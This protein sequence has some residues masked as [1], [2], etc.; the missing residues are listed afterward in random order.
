MDYEGDWGKGASGLELFVRDLALCLSVH[1]DRGPALVWPDGVDAVLS[2][3]G[4][5]RRGRADPGPEPDG[6]VA[7]TAE[8]TSG[9]GEL[10]GCQVGSSYLSL[11][12]G[13]QSTGNTAATDLVLLPVRGS[14]GG[15]VEPS[16]PGQAR[17]VLDRALELRLRVG[18]ALYVPS[19]FGYALNGAHSPCTL[20]VL[21]L[22][23]SA[24]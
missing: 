22:H 18:E 20:L 2:G 5:I 1:R 16:P 10:L 8:L 23:P 17:A 24:W 21:A 6:V 3:D 7:G 11:P 9:L 14:C 12:T 4:G 19:G 13:A 15:R